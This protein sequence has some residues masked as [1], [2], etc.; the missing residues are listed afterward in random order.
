M[1]VV[2][3]VRVRNLSKF[4]KKIKNESGLAMIN[5][6]FTQAIHNAKISELEDFYR[7]K[8]YQVI[9]KPIVEDMVF[10]LL[11]KK[12]DRQIIFDVKT[13]PLTTTAKENILRQQKL[14]KEKGLDFRLVTVSKPKSPSIDIE[15]L[16][17]ELL[18]ELMTI[19]GELDNLATHVSVDDVEFEYQSIH[20][21]NSETKVEVS[22][23]LY[24][25][26]QYG[27]NSDV[28]NDMGEGIGDSLDFS[29]SLLLDMLDS[30]I[31]SVDWRWATI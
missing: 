10:D 24:L 29:A 3:V 12:A 30:K 17:D 14:A 18:D 27:S 5:N 19:P 15:W 22:G 11:V 9:K 16:H 13:A 20:I 4:R 2:I 23:V 25:E 21:S 28:K 8:N 6:Y 7:N 31:I 26:L 1:K